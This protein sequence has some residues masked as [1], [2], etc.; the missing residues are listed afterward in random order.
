MTQEDP[1][2]INEFRASI[3]EIGASSFEGDEL[4]KSHGLWIAGGIVAAAI[5]IF[6]SAMKKPKYE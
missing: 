2:G 4:P 6:I 3:R 1:T 5:S